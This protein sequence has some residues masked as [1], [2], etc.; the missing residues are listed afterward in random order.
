MY[1]YIKKGQVNKLYQLYQPG[2]EVDMIPLY[3]HIIRN[4]MIHDATLHTN[5]NPAP[6]LSVQTR[7]PWGHVTAMRCG[8]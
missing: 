7:V 8:D 2:Y 1:E 5:K 4:L 3:V 6:Y